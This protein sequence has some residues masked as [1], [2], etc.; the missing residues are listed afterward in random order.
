MQEQEFEG[1]YGKVIE[2]VIENVVEKVAEKVVESQLWK[3]R[4][5]MSVR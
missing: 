4:P 5:H 1:R 3:L 2:S